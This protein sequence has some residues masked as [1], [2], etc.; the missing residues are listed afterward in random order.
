MLLDPSRKS[1]SRQ[2]VA[3]D[4][5]ATHCATEIGMRRLDH[6]VEAECSKEQR[7]GREEITNR[8]LKW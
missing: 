8:S 4:A 3:G 1:I 7:H 5:E 2:S 6:H